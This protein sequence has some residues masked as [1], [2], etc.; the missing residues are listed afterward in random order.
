M[1]RVGWRWGPKAREEAVAAAQTRGEKHLL[2]QV[3]WELGRERG[4][5][6][7]G[8]VGETGGGG[9]GREE[10]EQVAPVG[11]TASLGPGPGR[12]LPSSP[13]QGRRSHR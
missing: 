8:R 7:R 11:A 2:T 6:R 4:T 1:E 3:E 9:R 10:S 12:A 13:L 5:R